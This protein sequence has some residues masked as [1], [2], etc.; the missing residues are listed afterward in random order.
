MNIV[1][2]VFFQEAQELG[3]PDLAN[4]NPEHPLNLNFR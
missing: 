4:Q 2:M 1:R 3:L